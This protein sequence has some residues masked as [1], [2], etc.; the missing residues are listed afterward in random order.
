M[1]TPTST[2]DELGPLRRLGFDVPADCLLVVPKDYLDFTAPVSEVTWEDVGQN[3][4]FV[5][6][7]VARRMWTKSKAPCASLAR[8]WRMQVQCRM[9]SGDTIDVAVF[10]NLW[11]WSEVKEGR[12]L[13]VWGLVG[14]FADKLQITDPRLVA[15]HERGRVAPVY[16]GKPGQIKGQTVGEKVTQFMGLMDEAGHRLLAKALLRRSE[17]PADLGFADPHELL[18]ALHGPSCISRGLEAQAAAHRLAAEAV[19]RQ[20]A[21]ARVRAASFAS[22][23]LIRDQ[24][25][26]STISALPYALTGDQRIAITEIIDDLRSPYPMRRLLSGDV[27]TG[28]SV[29]FMVPAVAAYRCG[30]RVA[31]LAPSVLVVEQLARELRTMFP[32]VPVSELTAKSPAGE[33]ILIGTTALLNHAASRAL[34]FDLLIAD[35]QQKFG[36]QQKVRAVGANTNMLEATATAIPRTLAMVQFGAMDHSW[37][38][39]QPVRK[40]ITT[41]ITS[42]AC[43]VDQ[44][45]LRVY[46]KAALA[47]GHQLAVIYPQVGKDAGDDGSEG[48]KTVQAA[49]ARF[50]SYRPGRVG[51]LHGRM[52]EEEKI[53]VIR[54]M[55]AKEIDLLVSSIVIEIGVTLPSLKG[56]LIV[57]PER[58]GLGQIHQLRGRL[59]RNGGTAKL[60]LQVD[61]RIEDMRANRPETL[62]RLELLTRCTD[63]YELAERDMQRRG[64]GD[65]HAGAVAQSGT[66]RPLFWGVAPTL[67]ELA[68]AAARLT[69]TAAAAAARPK[70]TNRATP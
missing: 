55:H 19:L 31:I 53:N 11:P 22:A 29:V 64:F 33:G 63:G 21:N 39:Q 12:D 46:F 25:V 35:E 37:L 47:N 15:E 32:G 45:R 30:A 16:P 38:R 67:P 4:Y 3:V 70:H 48:Y 60:F 9:T 66:T 44:Q 51:C 57:N 17:F 34:T 23:L 8:A 50:E 18:G 41:Y 24:D 56:M 2:G 13:H 26:D 20:A 40:A 54:R 10:G 27:G 58:Y 69:S 14:T 68:E 49:A 59:A 28:K 62:D 1:P 43:P 7:V 65:V 36:N 52:S 42:K 61:D 6:A 5:G